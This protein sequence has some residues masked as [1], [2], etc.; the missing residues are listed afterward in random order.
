MP[1]CFSPGEQP[2]LLPASTLP[3]PDERALQLLLVGYRDPLY[4]SCAVDAGVV[5]GAGGTGGE[6]MGKVMWG[7]DTFLLF[8]LLISVVNILLIYCIYFLV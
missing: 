6:E 7:A 4:H 3:F 2:L 1:P 5:T 8:L